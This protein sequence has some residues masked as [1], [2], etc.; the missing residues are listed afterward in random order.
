MTHINHCRGEK[1][2]GIRELDRFR[3]KL[4]PDHQ[5]LKS[6]EHKV[7]SKIGKIF[8]NEDTLEERSVKIYKIDLY[9][10]ENYKKRI[11][12]DENGQQVILIETLF[13]KIKDKRH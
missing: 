8:V 5:I 13:S 11:Q 9:F 2:R 10:S 6:I 7:K 12:V 3:K 1:K 4:M